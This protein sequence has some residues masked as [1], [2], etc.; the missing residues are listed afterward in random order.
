MKAIC[1]RCG[2]LKVSASIG[3]DACGHQPQTDEDVAASIMLSGQF[4]SD[5]KLREASALIKRG[6]KIPFPPAVFNAVLLAVK[7]AKREIIKKRDHRKRNI[8]LTSASVAILAALFL[9]FHPWL[10]YNLASRKD[11]VAA[12]ETF[13]RKFPTGEYAAS[14]KERVRVLSHDSVW[15]QAKELRRPFMLRSY[16]SNYPDGKH[17]D[18]ARLMITE[19]ANARWI[20]EPKPYSSDQVK[21]FRKNWPEVDSHLMESEIWKDAQS[22]NE[23]SRI[24][25]YQSLYPD[26]KF[27]KAAL[28]LVS[29]IA[30]QE[31]SNVMKSRSPEA[32]FRFTESFPETDRRSQAD[33]LLAEWHNDPTWVD[34]QNSIAAFERFIAQNPN[35]QQR[36]YFEKRIID[37]EVAEIAAGEHGKLP[38]SQP[39]N[40][41]ARTRSAISEVEIK[42]ST[43]YEITIRY[44][45]SDSRK[46]MIAAG[47]SAVVSL[48]SGS[49]K[50]TASAN[51]ARVT[52]YYG[53]EELTGGRYSSEFYIQSSNSPFGRTR[54]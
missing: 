5:A 16:I 7:S 14:A 44:S 22:Q 31:W 11:S 33:T 39:V 18:E 8:I 43:G 34:S 40:S 36:K 20:Q 21:N 12:Y 28:A 35:S 52:N 29:N 3:C 41:W 47:K 24:R 42:N 10:H 49:Y 4:L 26:G 45:G 25:T 1:H 30:D 38:Q 54:F 48:P 27:T 2:S 19:E 50:I 23:L 15:S 32:I 9:V 46:I 17:L 51:A 13:L 53:E 6:H 37:L